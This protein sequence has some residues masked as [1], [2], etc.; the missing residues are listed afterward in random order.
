MDAREICSE[1]SQAGISFSALDHIVVF[2]HNDMRRYLLTS[3]SL[4]MIS[5]RQRISMDDVLCD[6]VG[7][8]GLGAED[9][10]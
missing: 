2:H 4:L 5:C 8:S 3:G 7:R 1:I 6:G 10:R 9:Q